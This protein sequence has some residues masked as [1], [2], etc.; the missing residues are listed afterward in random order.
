MLKARVHDGAGCAEEQ[1]D[2][3]LQEEAEGEGFEPS[4]SLHP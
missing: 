4:K 2:A 1:F 3:T